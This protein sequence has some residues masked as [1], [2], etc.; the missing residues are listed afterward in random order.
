MQRMLQYRS[1]SAI[2]RP[3][4]LLHSPCGDRRGLGNT[5]KLIDRDPTSELHPSCNKNPRDPPLAGVCICTNPVAQCPKLVADRNFP[6]S[7]NALSGR[8]SQNH[9]MLASGQRPKL[10]LDLRRKTS[11][12]ADAPRRLPHG[13]P[14]PH[15][16][17]LPLKETEQLELP[18]L[19]VGSRSLFHGPHRGRLPN[20]DLVRLC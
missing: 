20:L 2:H 18:G 12:D 8:V 9:S 11:L 15:A 4:P 7:T 17:P 14:S 5:F 13:S 19:L 3:N 16:D 6:P 1:E 10:I